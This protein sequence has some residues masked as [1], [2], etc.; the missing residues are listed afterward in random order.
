MSEPRNPASKTLVLDDDPTGTQCASDVDVLLG[1]DALATFARSIAPSAYLLTNTRALSREQAINVISDI[2]ARVPAPTRL[3]LRGDST[4]RGHVFAEMTAA[5]LEEG[6]GLIAPAF[7]A[8]GRVTV[9]GVHYLDADGERVNVADTEFAADPVFGFT[10][11]TMVEWVHE[12]SPGRT[13]VSVG[14]DELAATGP[15]AVA[16]ALIDAPTSAVV[17]PD[18]ASDDDVETV[19][20]GYEQATRSTR[21]V[22][23]RCAAPLAASIAGTKGRLLDRVPAPAS[24]CLVVCGSHTEAATKQLTQLGRLTGEPV[25]LNTPALLSPRDAPDAVQEA[26]AATSATLETERLAVLASERL[27]SAS[28][29]TLEDGAAVMAGIV[30]VVRNLVGQFDALVTKGG[31]T[32]ADVVTRGLRARRARVMGQLEVGVPVWHVTTDHAGVPV[33]VVPGNV[34]TGVTL[35]NAVHF[36]APE[37]LHSVRST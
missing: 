31:I 27:R 34:G 13:V 23:V 32:S 25:T 22:I 17:L 5:G 29:S 36:L 6:V 8:A 21:P 35:V 19:W 18:I 3:V 15:D 33:V 10:A 2:K 16:R 37:L 24:R 30:S 1:S 14:S 4:L 7:P 12:L 20:R 11:R 9:D 26:T 28:H